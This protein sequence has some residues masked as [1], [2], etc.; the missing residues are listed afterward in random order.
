MMTPAMFQSRFN[1]DVRIRHEVT[2]IN[3]KNHEIE[4]RNLNDGLTT[5][6]KYDRLILTIGTV[7]FVPP[8]NGVDAKNVFVLRNM[9]DVDRVRQYLTSQ[10]VKRA[11]VVGAGFIGLEV[12]EVL[13]EGGVSVDLIE[14]EQQVLPPLDPDVACRVE[15][16]LKKNGVQL[17]LGAPLEGIK[18]DGDMVRAVVLP[19]GETIETDLVL[20]GIGVRPCSQLAKDAGLAMGER[21]HIQVNEHLQTSDPDILAAGD[22]IEVVHT[23]TDQPTAIPLAGPA[24]KHGRL[25]GEMAVMDKCAPAA[26]VA[27]TAVVKVFGLT[28]GSTGLS[29]KAAKRLGLNVAHSLVRRPHHVTYYP[30]A[31]QMTIKLTYE[32]GSGKVLGCQIVG[33]ADVARRLDVAASV[34]HFGGTIEDMAQLDLAYAPPYGAAKDPLHMAAFVA[35]NQER[36]L[37]NHVFVEDV[38]A[39]QQRG[40]TFVDVRT[41]RETEAGMLPGALHVEYDHIRSNVDRISR[42]KP[43]VVYCRTGP[44]S[45]NVARL[46]MNIG[47]REVYNLAG[48]F[49]NYSTEKAAGR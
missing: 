19:S 22:V 6:E 9:E 29:V 35:E 30:G 2:A 20:L 1:I 4:V 11:A 8:I 34:L 28:A 12:A 3:R 45:Y 43:V 48:G 49:E 36:G 39:L 21:G 17:H 23:V 24:N 37:V 26:K 32:K 38:L 18:C 7:P 41:A 13:A 47:Y 16:E 42:E 27:G 15:L 33:G 40:A 14:M 31:E 25:A 5:R 44:R 10:S 46:L